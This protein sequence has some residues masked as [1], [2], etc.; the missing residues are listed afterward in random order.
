MGAIFL[1]SVCDEGTSNSRPGAPHNH[2]VSM[3]DKLITAPSNQINIDW[4]SWQ[5]T[6]RF[7]SRELFDGEIGV[8]KP[9]IIHNLGTF[10]WVWRTD[11]CMVD[12]GRQD[13]SRRSFKPPGCASAGGS[14]PSFDLPRTC[15][16][17]LERDHS[18]AQGSR[19]NKINDIHTLPRYDILQWPRV[20]WK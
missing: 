14:W 10:T 7:P 20:F 16:E 8:A 17:H 2:T 13:I 5:K 9:T 1:F 12:M 6:S 15:Q 19:T 11:D 18:T 3:H 4:W